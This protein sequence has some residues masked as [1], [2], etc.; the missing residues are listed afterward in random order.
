[1]KLSVVTVSYNNLSD[2]QLT[3]NSLME[4]TVLD[5]ELIIS[6]GGSKDDVVDYLKALSPTFSYKYI[7]ASDLGPY[8]GMNRGVKVATGDYIWFLNAGDQAFD[9]ES[10]EIIL[11][12]LRGKFDIYFF[13]VLC[14]SQNLEYIKG[15]K[16]LKKSFVMDMP[17]CH[18]GMIFKKHN[19]LKNPFNL[20]YKISADYYHLMQQIFLLNKSFTYVPKP[21]AIFDL[22]GISSNNWLENFIEQLKINFKFLS[23]IN[24]PMLAIK[25]LRRI[26]YFMISKTLRV[27]KKFEVI[28]KFF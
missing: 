21:I 15:R 22:S 26:L 5:F 24:Y 20:K 16:V 13:D 10:I 11:T 9:K 25:I 8:D 4:Q 27:F 18:Q 2:L 12:R 19:L 23:P 1:M 28:R 7:S 6:D 3:V 14:R 17:I